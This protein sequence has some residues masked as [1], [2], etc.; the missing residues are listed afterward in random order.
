MCIESRYDIVLEFGLLMILTQT[1]QVYNISEHE[2]LCIY[3][4]AKKDDFKF[5]KAV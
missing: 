3:L 4:K 2:D 1:T 5:K